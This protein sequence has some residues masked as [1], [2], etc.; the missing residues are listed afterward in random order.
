MK[1]NLILLLFILLI[2]TTLSSCADN[3]T[4]IP[5][6][7]KDTPS[8]N[9]KHIQV[10][11]QFYHE[12]VI[13]FEN[14]DLTKS[15]Y[16][17]SSPVYIKNKDSY[18]ICNNTIQTIVEADGRFA[19]QNSRN[20]IVSSLPEK[21]SSQNGFCIQFK[22]TKMQIFPQT[23]VSKDA[24]KTNHINIFGK[25]AE[26]LYYENTFN[27]N[28]YIY[29]ND[30]GVNTETV[31]SNPNI[32]AL[33]YTI[34][35]DNVELDTSC[36]D[37]ILF[38]SVK[39][40]DVKGIVYKPIIVEK[41]GNALNGAMSETCNMTVSNT[42]KG[43]YTITITLSK[44]FTENVAFPLTVSQSFHI[45]RPKQP[46][47]AIY[48]NSNIGYYL[49]DKVIIGSDP[50]KGE[51]HLLVRFETLD[52]LNITSNDILSA[53][54]IISEVSGTT[55]PATIAMYPVLSEWCSINTRW[56]TKPVYA[57]DFIQK[58][59]VVKSGDYSFDVTELLKKW[60]ENRGLEVEYIIRHGFVLVNE[61]PKSPKLFATGDNGIFTSCL[62]IELKKDE[63]RK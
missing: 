20:D 12:N 23:D 5:Y 56:N 10:L 41:G 35:I 42:G 9:K 31:I 59:E 38:R 26:H 52:L 32:T 25:I 48:S 4:G 34:A 11:K 45:Y 27:S 21:L 29:I 46:D 30:F 60:L 53:E 44:T 54:Y 33:A 37:Y 15:L 40:D 13:C 16:M 14:D 6:L 3:A 62:K 63:A 17:Y 61:T 57:K 58:V 51:G 49:N 47:M 36:P 1:K 8:S 22:N 43:L 24:R 50:I 28:Y 19:Y 7:T 18:E 39:E 2:T 55:Q